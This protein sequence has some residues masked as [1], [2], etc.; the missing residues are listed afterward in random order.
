MT[1]R[2]QSSEARGY[3]FMLPIINPIINKWHVKE[4]K[5]KDYDTYGSKDEAVK[6]A[7]KKLKKQNKAMWLYIE[8]TANLKP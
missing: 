4:V 1:G 7:E 6:Q 5:A 2:G 3:L 8:K